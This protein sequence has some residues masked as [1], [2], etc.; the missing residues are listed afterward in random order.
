MTAGSRPSTRRYLKGEQ[1]REQILQ[2]AK[3]L[4]M[5]KGYH[6]TS[7]YDLFEK[8][9]ITKGAFYHHWRTK[10][11]LALTILE[12]MRSAYETRIFTLVHSNGRARDT[13]EQALRTIRGLNS[14]PDWVYCRLLATW[15]AELSRDDG[16]LAKGV[17]E[18]R[19][20]WRDFWERI[21]ARAQEE[22]DLRRDISAKELSLLMSGTLMGV[23]IGGTGDG[24]MNAC[25]VLETMRKI[26][27][28]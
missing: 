22:G 1:T 28:T 3:E 14:R 5:R 12:E 23:Y 7:I 8:A 9:A 16:Q 4:F 26:L 25:D 20:R 18:M 17:R 27:F 6:N 21:L 19:Q 10:E 24:S 11:E 15:S 2:A 13:I